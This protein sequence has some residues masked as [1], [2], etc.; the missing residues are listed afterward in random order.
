MA[1]ESTPIDRSN[2]FERQHATGG[3]VGGRVRS[4][5]PSQDLP[6]ERV[7]PSSWLQPD[8]QTPAQK[9]PH[10]FKNVDHLK[11]ID[12]YRVLKMWQ[13]TDPCIQH[14]VKKLLVA[15]KR[16]NKVM[17]IDVKEAIVALERFIQMLDED[18]TPGYD[19]NP[20]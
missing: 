16:G 6:G 18:A 8:L 3:L 7:V 1:D 15:G 11:D 5:G 19:E 10:Y 14:A 13:V 20:F 4:T 9:F 2:S 17:S 12:I